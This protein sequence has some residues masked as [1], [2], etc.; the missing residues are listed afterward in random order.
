LGL[1]T[2]EAISFGSLFI[3]D[4][5]A[6]LKSRL[7][8][9]FKRISL[10][11]LENLSNVFSCENSIKTSGSDMATVLGSCSNNWVNN[12][13]PHL[14]VFERRTNLVLGGGFPTVTPR[15]TN[16]SKGIRIKCVQ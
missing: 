16:D 8:H 9:D 2:K 10:R 1:I 14:P 7:I 6:D 15:V 4:W 3:F 11:V 13:D 12:V 5:L